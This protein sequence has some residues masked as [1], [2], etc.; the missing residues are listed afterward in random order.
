ML[1]A[2]V[3][4]LSCPTKIKHFIWQVVSGSVAV[5]SRLNQRRINCDTI[6]SR[7]RVAEEMINYFLFECPTVAITLDIFPIPMGND[8]F[9]YS[10]VFANFD[11]VFWR[12]P[13]KI[14]ESG[15]QEMF[16]WLLWFIWK[17]RNKKVFQGVD[18]EP[19]YIL[20]LAVSEFSAW[21]DA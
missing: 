11:F 21:N 10:S 19:T 17:S 15:D 7:C 2:H 3:W 4:K 20:H 12:N 18:S 8:M 5:S 13:R 9:P 14:G 16:T 6:C 1:K